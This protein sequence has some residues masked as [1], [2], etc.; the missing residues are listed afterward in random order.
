MSRWLFI[1]VLLAGCSEVKPPAA[2]APSSKPGRALPRPTSPVASPAPEGEPPADPATLTRSWSVQT[3]PLLRGLAVTQSHVIVQARATLTV[4]DRRVGK[5]LASRDVCEAGRGA[6]TAT[7]KHVWLMCPQALQSFTL[8][9]LKPSTRH[10]LA[11]PGLR[12][13]FSSGRA[14]VA[15]KDGLVREVSLG[16]GEVV[17]SFA[18]G[19]PPEALAIGPN[20]RF[21]AG[22]DGGD[23]I[24]YSPDGATER[25]GAPAGF[26][27]STLHYAPDD[28]HLVVS[29][30]P[31]V[32]VWRLAETDPKPLRF[33]GV[34]EL[35]DARWLGE[36]YLATV[37]PDGVLVLDVQTREVAALSG[38]PGGEELI[39]I[40][41][42]GGAAL[43]A[44]DRNGRVTCW[45]PG[46]PRNVAPTDAAPGARCA[47]T[48]ARVDG[49]ALEVTAEAG[50]PLPKT[51][52]KVTLRRFAETTA[53]RR[54]SSVWL[55]VARARV[56]EVDG[57]R[58]S[59]KLIGPIGFAPVE[60]PVLDAGI[61]VELRW[62]P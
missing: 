39:A 43:C 13:A 15:S 41:S 31:S 20:G 7:S 16:S 14:L 6:V 61:L 57:A 58:L 4:L 34:R 35:L 44:G 3:A 37:G 40:G 8:P 25:V 48:I 49:R 24:V 12:V 54:R 10:A 30:G 42:H 55:E 2:P 62:K 51:G 59:L 47:G 17:R 1:F 22:R 21:A 27:V 28:Q 26:A 36:R 38:D 18:V 5:V 23:V 33:S 60:G 9:D 19:T 53:K 29:A 52:T 46:R 45:G 56:V 11:S 32:A 50:A